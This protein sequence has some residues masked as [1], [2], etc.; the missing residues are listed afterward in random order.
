[1]PAKKKGAKKKTKKR[2]G[3]ATLNAKNPWVMIIPA[4]VGLLSGAKVNAKLNEMVLHDKVDGKIVGFGEL[5]V[6][7][8]LMFIKFGKKKTVVEVVTGSFAAGLGV[9]KLLSEFGVWPE[10]TAVT[11]YKQTPIVARRPSSVRRMSGFGDVPVIGAP[12]NQG[13]KTKGAMNGSGANGYGV[14]KVLGHV[15]SNSNGNGSGMAHR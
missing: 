3:K 2:I 14:S 1:M 6:G 5:G 10:T 12:D 8:G 11:G 15:M 7:A 13:Y 4:A 9:R